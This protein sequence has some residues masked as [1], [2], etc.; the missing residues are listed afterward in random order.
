MIVAKQVN[1]VS[2]VDNI[3]ALLVDV[4]ADVKAGK[5][6]ATVVSEAV[7]GFVKALSGLGELSSDVAHRK[8]LEVTVALRLAEVVNVLA[9]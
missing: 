6:P 4:V 8:D 2:S 5:A 7:P 1:I 9:S 3:L